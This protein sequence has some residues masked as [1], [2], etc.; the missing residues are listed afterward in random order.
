MC[1]LRA[2]DEVLSVNRHKVAEMSYTDWKSCMEEALQ[3][4]SL[5]MDIRRHGKNSESSEQCV[6]VCVFEGSWTDSPAHAACVSKQL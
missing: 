4:G 6:C 5:V 1:Q 2:G 3:E